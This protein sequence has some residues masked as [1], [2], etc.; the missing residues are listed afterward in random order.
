MENF[1]VLGVLRKKRPALGNGH[2]AV[3][4]CLK[5]CPYAHGGGHGVKHGVLHALE[6]PADG[7]DI[8]AADDLALI[9]DGAAV[10]QG[11]RLLEP[12]LGQK[13][14]RAEL[15]VYPAEHGEEITGCNGVEPARGLVQNEHL[16]LH[17]HDGSEV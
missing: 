15:T 11:Q 1:M 17:R 10:G 14:A 16:R 4:V 9:H 3:G 13:N 6:C 8:A 7:F 2:G 5:P 12:L